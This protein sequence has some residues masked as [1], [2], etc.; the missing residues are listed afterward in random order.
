MVNYLAATTL[1]VIPCDRSSYPTPPASPQLRGQLPVAEPTLPSL[2]AF[3]STLV[4]RSNVQTPTLMT[5]LVY[6]ARLRNRLPSAAKG[7][8]CTCHRIFLAALILAAKNLND[9]SPK[10]KYWANYTEGLF[11]LV[12][13]NLMEKQLLYLLDW[14]LRVTNKDLIHHFAPF[15]EPIRDD[16]VR[17]H[18]SERPQSIVYRPYAS[19]VQPLHIPSPPSSQHSVELRGRSSS[20]Q[21]PSSAESLA[22]AHGASRTQRGSH[23]RL[24][25]LSGQGHRQIPPEPVLSAST[26]LSSLSSLESPLSVRTPEVTPPYDKRRLA[27]LPRLYKAQSDRIAIQSKL[28][29]LN[30]MAY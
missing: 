19:P 8:A 18:A 9:S 26:S 11:P 7:M 27:L 4:T 1:T 15:L 16:I 2:V 22:S 10:N 25:M 6:L 13:V 12:E 17:Q 28:H 5:S 3:I 14:D 23:T 30:R 29:S 21:S 24:K 20:S